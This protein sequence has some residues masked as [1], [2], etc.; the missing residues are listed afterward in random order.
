MLVCSSCVDQKDCQKRDYVNVEVIN[1]HDDE[2]VD[3]KLKITHLGKW[4]QH[5]NSVRFLVCFIMTLKNKKEKGDNWIE[6]VEI[7]LSVMRKHFTTIM[8]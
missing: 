5:R 8:Y 2:L 3:Y 1:L 7:K 6:A 4:M